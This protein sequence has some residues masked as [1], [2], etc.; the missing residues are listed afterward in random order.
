MTAPP[1]IDPTTGEV[2]PA[3]R[4]PT[5]QGL[6]GFPS[7]TATRVA[8]PARDLTRSKWFYGDLLGLPVVGGFE[9][10]DGYDGVFFALPGGG[11]LE[12][13]AGP[14]QPAPS[15]DEDLLV[16]YVET[17]GEVE[18]VSARL[19]AAGIIRIPSGNPY[20]NRTGQTFV[21]PDGYRL[22]VATTSSDSPIRHRDK[23]LG[24]LL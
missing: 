21:D 20:W 14:E 1:R 7:W 8:R 2:D 13:T 12:L 18:A 17:W 6:Q 9:N 23:R 4:Q 11:E 19:V 5:D 22:V 10:H 15:T 3:S 16:L 24:P